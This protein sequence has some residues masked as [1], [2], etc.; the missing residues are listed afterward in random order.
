MAEKKPEMSKDAAEC[1]LPDLDSLAQLELD[2]FINNATQLA[3]KN[4]Q[5]KRMYSD[6]GG[7]RSLS[8]LEEY[9]GGLI[10]GRG[11]YYQDL[12][13][14]PFY[15]NSGFDLQTAHSANDQITPITSAMT[16][17]SVLYV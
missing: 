14:K 4:R 5:G 13:Q 3:V 11:E 17:L 16:G 12:C 9:E 1:A 8:L 15:V 6:G 2:G 10:H 7:L